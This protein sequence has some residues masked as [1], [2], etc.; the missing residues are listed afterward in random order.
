MRYKWSDPNTQIARTA[1]IFSIDEIVVFH[2]PNHLNTEQG[3]H[4]Q[5]HTR[6][7]YRQTSG[8]NE[9]A[10][11]GDENDMDALL[12]RILEYLETPQ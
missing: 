9:V 4:G 1:A 11:G 5:G 6:G 3:S 8:S 12:G 10:D 7:K 2:E